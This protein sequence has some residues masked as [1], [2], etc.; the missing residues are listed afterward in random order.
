ML[1]LDNSFTVWSILVIV[2]FDFRIFCYYCNKETILFRFSDKICS[3]MCKQELEIG[4]S[5]KIFISK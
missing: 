4:D 2:G 3:N 1:W 5:V